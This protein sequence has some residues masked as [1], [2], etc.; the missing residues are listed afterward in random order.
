MILLL[1]SVI[2]AIVITISFAPE[3]SDLAGRIKYSYNPM[4]A[5]GNFVYSSEELITILS[6]KDKILYY[7]FEFL[8]VVMWIMPTLLVVTLV[9]YLFY[10]IKIKKTIT[11][12]IR[13]R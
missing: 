8:S 13:K 5:N 12:F 6:A 2:L 9:P 1:P 3:L 7:L 4:D 10:K 11:T